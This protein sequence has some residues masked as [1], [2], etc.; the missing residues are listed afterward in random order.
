MLLVGAAGERHGG[1]HR[2]VVVDFLHQHSISAN[3]RLCGQPQIAC[4]IAM[5]SNVSTTS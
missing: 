1:E 2:Q 4:N 5:V 3:S